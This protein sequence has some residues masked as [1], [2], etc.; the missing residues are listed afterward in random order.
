M[1]KTVTVDDDGKKKVADSK[2]VRTQHPS[3][4]ESGSLKIVFSLDEYVDI[5]K[6]LEE[7]LLKIGEKVVERRSKLIGHIK[8]TVMSVIGSE[9]RS[10]KC[11]LVDLGLGVDFSGNLPDRINNAEIYFLTVVHGLEEEELNKIVKDAA[12]ET[13]KAYKIAFEI[14]PYVHEH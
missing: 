10:L 13:F 8:S 12:T 3:G 9:E 1:D 14:R 2:P 7:I 4:L 5:R 6:P 11:S